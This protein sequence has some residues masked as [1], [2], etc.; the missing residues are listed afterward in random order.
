VTHQLSPRATLSFT[1]NLKITDFTGHDTS[2][3]DMKSADAGGRLVYSLSRDMGLRLGYTYRRADYVGSP[4]AT[5]QDFD[6]GIDYNRPLSR[7]RKTT[8]AV[9]LGPAMA[10][11]PLVIGSA[12]LRQQ[13]RMV[14]DASIK[15]Q[16]GRTW[17]LQ[18]VY[19]R[20]LGYIEGLQAPVFSEAYGATMSGSLTQRIDLSMNAAFST[21]ESALTGTPSQFSTYTGSGRLRY[22]VTRTWAVYG[23]YIFYYYLFNQNVPL[24]VGV[25]PGL[26]R[27][28]IRTGLILLVPMRRR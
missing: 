19:H 13:F 7:T 20:G 6:F 11:A 14:G 16:I 9:S 22:A 28:G 8:L 24:P 21:G 25:S 5:E 4:H 26:T 3:P 1:S 2:Y 10:T 12:D 15:H 17:T 18:G 27:N 23:E